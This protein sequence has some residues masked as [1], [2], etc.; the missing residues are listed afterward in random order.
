[1]SCKQTADV[2]PAQ[3]SV[4]IALDAGIPQREIA[5]SSRAMTGQFV[6][7]ALFSA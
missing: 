7:S 3:H 5:R 1:M 4:I 6:E 2:I